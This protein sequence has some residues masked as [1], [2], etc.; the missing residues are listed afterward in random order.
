MTYQA[1]APRHELADLTARLYRFMLD[2]EAV[3]LQRKAEARKAAGD[4][5]AQARELCQE[6]EETRDRVS[7]KV[8]QSIEETTESLRTV[9]DAME[10]SASARDFR[11]LWH[12][13]GE[14]YEALLLYVERTAGRLNAGHLKPRNLARNLFHVSMGVVSVGLYHFVLGKV[15]VVSI[16]VG[17][18]V[19]FAAIDLSRRFSSRWNDLLVNSLFS[20]I[21]RPGEAHRI[22]AATWYLTAL[23]LGVLLLPKAAIEL[24]TLILAFGD[25]AASLVGKRWGGRKLY[26]E[27]SYAGS[28][29][30]LATG[31]LAGLGYLLWLGPAMTIWQAVLVALVATVAGAV[32]EV[33]SNRVDDNFSIP[34]AAGAVATGVLS[35]L[36]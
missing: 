3:Y 26:R 7:D 36:S 18:L 12:N 4:L 1:T 22:P 25:P 10:R 28:L 17:L 6:F 16:L 9:L 24:G 20:K 30:F 32:A 8:R 23:L 13:L 27:K 19:A 21:S 34:L 11:R 29:G 31:S 33:F 2:A 14:R 15:A 35:L 5:A